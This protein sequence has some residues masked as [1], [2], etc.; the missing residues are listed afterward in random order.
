[1]IPN[2]SITIADAGNSQAS[3]SR[4]GGGDD[5]DDDED[6]EEEGDDDDDGLP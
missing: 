2:P 3:P 5:D 6:E 4:G 1:L